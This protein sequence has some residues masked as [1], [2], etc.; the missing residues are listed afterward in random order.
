MFIQ[1]PPGGLT[2]GLDLWP[3]S[4]VLSTAREASGEANVVVASRNKSSSASVSL[5]SCVPEKGEKKS[6]Q[7]SAPLK[8]PLP[9]L[10]RLRHLPQLVVSQGS[11]H[12]KMMRREKKKI[13]SHLSSGASMWHS[14]FF[15]GGGGFCAKLLS[16]I[17]CHSEARH[18]S[19]KQTEEH[20][21]PE[22]LA[23]SVSGATQIRPRADAVIYLRI[24]L[25]DKISCKL[26]WLMVLGG[27]AVS[28]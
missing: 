9:R 4:K 10:P 13:P 23:D 24:E 16:L 11:N 3:A 7:L 27:S 22:W 21:S 8:G 5:T 20:L 18:I 1:G 19:L 25:P 12:P 26:G 6:L 14:G 28:T 17:P 2:L 15:L